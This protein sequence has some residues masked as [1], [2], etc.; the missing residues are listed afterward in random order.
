MQLGDFKRKYRYKSDTDANKGSY[1]LAIL[2]SVVAFLVIWFL[3]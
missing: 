2:I 3:F 1:W